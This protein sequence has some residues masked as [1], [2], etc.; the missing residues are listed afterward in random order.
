MKAI[1]VVLTV[2]GLSVFSLTASAQAE[3]TKYKFFDG[4]N[5]LVKVVKIT[6]FGVAS[7]CCETVPSC[8]RCCR[9]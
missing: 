5:N 8:R 7:P 6:R 2:F 4:C 1:A 3:V 9:W